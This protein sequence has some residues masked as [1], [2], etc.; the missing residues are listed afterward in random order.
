MSLTFELG[1]SISGCLDHAPHRE[2]QTI[3]AGTHLVT[4]VQNPC[5]HGNAGIILDIMS[6]I[7]LK[8]SPDITSENLISELKT[9][10]NSSLAKTALKI[11]DL[12][13]KRLHG[14]IFYKPCSVKIIS[15]SGLILNEIQFQSP[16]LANL[17]QKNSTVYP[18]IITCLGETD[19]IAD[20]NDL[21][22]EFCL[23]TIKTMVLKQTI[24][25]FEK[26]LISTHGYPLS[27]AHPGTMKDWNISELRLIFN[28]LCIDTESG[29]VRLTKGNVMLP[30]KTTAGIA[31]HSPRHFINC[32]SCDRAD[33]PE[34]R[35]PYNGASADNGR[36]F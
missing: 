26:N 7:K 19:D 10:D 18:N 34:R 33:C 13:Q 23:E 6:L 36:Q 25:A 2:D 20:P 29:P 17:L 14:G 24:A 16:T 9:S 11:L 15:S 3:H 5:L 21:M 4:Q 12:A 28:L 35:A 30:L 8:I 32:S 27:F 31:F 22:E 1:I